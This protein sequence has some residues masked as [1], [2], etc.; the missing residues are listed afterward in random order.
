MV[1]PAPQ[2]EEMPMAT[3][4]GVE[5]LAP[6]T[7]AQ[8]IRSAIREIVEREVGEDLTGVLLF[9]SRAR[10]EGEADS[11]WDVAVLVRGQADPRTITRRL[12]EAITDIWGDARTL[13][14]PIVLRPAD[15]EMRPSLALNLH[16]HATPL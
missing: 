4:S 13:V 7:G 6:P 3:K 14:R 15:L 12:L 16:D 9:G 8:A 1:K 5:A 2:R 10:G 11:D